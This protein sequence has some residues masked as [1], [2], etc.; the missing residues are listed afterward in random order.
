MAKPIMSPVAYDAQKVLMALEEFLALKIDAEYGDAMMG[1]AMVGHT[2][3]R[4]MVSKLCELKA[5]STLKATPSKEVEQLKAENKELKDKLAVAI[6]WALNNYQAV[7]SLV[8]YQ[9]VQPKQADAHPAWL[10]IQHG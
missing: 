1:Q 6:N 8:K 10:N 9:Q 7:E 5:D 3:Y 2:T 4:D